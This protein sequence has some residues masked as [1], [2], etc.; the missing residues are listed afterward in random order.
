MFKEIVTRALT[1]VLASVLVYSGLTSVANAQERKDPTDPTNIQLQV[2]PAYEYS[3]LANSGG[4]T[5]TLSV[6]TWIPLSEQDLL[7]IEVKGVHADPMSPFPSATGFG[8]MR[9]RYFHLI[10]TP[11][12]GILRAWAP[13]FD[14]IIPTGN[15][16]DGTGGGSWLLIPNF[17]LALQLTPG[18]SA[19][20]FFRYVHGISTGSGPDGFLTSALPELGVPVEDPSRVSWLGLKSAEVRGLNIEVPITFTLTD[21]LFFT[22]TPNFFH[23]FPDGGSTTFSSKFSITYAPSADMNMGLEVF[24]PIAG[25]QGVD[26]SVKPSV[27]FVF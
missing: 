25:E 22:A 7:T 26:F 17:L 2:T 8:D 23:N 24:V 1:A 6:D 21:E 13:S 10:S 3:S 14:L 20:P 18:I 11:D 15:A 16:S 5:H 12:S 27:T 19:Y 4:D 9:A